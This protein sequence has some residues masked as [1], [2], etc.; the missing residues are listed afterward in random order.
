MKRFKV[1]FLFVALISVAF[2]ITACGGSS[3]S[4][5]GGGD[6]STFVGSCTG[7]PGNVMDGTC[8]DYYEGYTVQDGQTACAALSDIY[9]SDTCATE[10]ANETKVP[11]KCEVTDPPAVNNRL[12]QIS[13]YEPDY[14]LV[15]AQLMCNGIDS[16]QDYTGTWISD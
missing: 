5:S 3:S 15:R 4:D 13:F 11:G 9:S 2:L 7:A 6:S 14:D 1:F 12:S 10:N 16:V 8:T